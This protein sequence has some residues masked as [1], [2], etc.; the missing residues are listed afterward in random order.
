[1]WCWGKVR[2]GGNCFACYD[3]DAAGE[4]VKRRCAAV[5]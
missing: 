5:A 2:W 1:M 4:G 3:I